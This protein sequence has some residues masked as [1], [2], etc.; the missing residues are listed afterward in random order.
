MTIIAF[1]GAGKMAEAIIS[2]LD[3]PSNIMAADV[4]KRRLGYLKKKY[5]IGLAKDNQEAFAKGEIVVL[6]VKPQGV[7]VVVAELAPQLGKTKQVLPLLVSIVAGI[8]LGYLRKKLPGLPI[9]RAMPNNP[10]LVGMGIT[11]LAKDNLVSGRQYKK[12]E[13]IFKSVGKVI[14]V[15]E[16]WM[17]AVT[18]LSGSGPAFVYE[19]LDALIG[20]GV[21]AGLPRA[22]ATKLAVQTVLGAATT[23]KK[24]GKSPKELREMVASK[25]GTTVEGLKIIKKARV[26]QALSR[27]VVAA[28]NKSKIISKKWTS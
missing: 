17:D 20:G 10:C 25:G 9:I 11:A 19:T 8:P 16:K 1:V 7:G 27:A 18:G 6:A 4:S 2:K 13:A 5:K 26:K 15:P 21:A 23:V 22:I 28:A 3:L 24:T 14:G 12:I